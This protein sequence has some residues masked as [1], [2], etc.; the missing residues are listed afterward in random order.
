[1]KTKLNIK[2]NKNVL[3]FL[4]FLA[5][6]INSY[7]QNCA[8]NLGEVTLQNIVVTSNTLEYDIYV[9]NIGTT[10]LK[11][12][13]FNGNAVY[14]A[15]LLGAGTGTFTVIQ[16][17]NVC[18]FPTL[19]NIVL[20]HT[21]ASQQLRYTQTIQ[22]FA[23]GNQ[24]D[25]PFNVSMKFAR[26]RLT[27]SVPFA[28]TSFTLRLPNGADPV[29]I[30]RNNLTVTCN[31]N[32]NTTNLVGNSAPPTLNVGGPYNLNVPVVNCPTS[33]TW[34]GTTWSNGAP[35]NTLH[36]IFNGNYSSTASID[37]CQVTIGNNSNVTINPNHTL[38]VNYEI[39]VQTGS[40]LTIENDAAIKQVNN[41]TNTGNTIIKR[42]SAPIIRLDYTAW[43]SPVSG[44]QLLSFSPNTL[45]NRFYTYDSNGTTTATAFL[46]IAPTNNFS[47]GV[48]YLIRAANDW[49]PT[50]YS[51]FNGTY[52]GILNNGTYNVPIG[53][54]YNMI[55]NPYA[56]PIN[57]QT[58]LT[59]NATIGT[60]Y[61]WTHTI[62]A[63]GS[64]YPTNN[65]ASFTTLGGAAA[66]AGGT[67]PNG[68]IQTGQGFFVNSSAATNAV[69]QNSLRENATTSTQFYRNLNTEKHRFWV[70]LNGETVNHNQILIGYMDTATNSVDADIDGKLIDDSSSVIY[71]YL[72]NE[73]YVI[74][75]KTLPFVD[76]DIV[77]LG[78]KIN[79]LG[80]YT[81]NLETKDGIFT[82]QNI[83]LK[84][85]Y[86]NTIQ[87]LDASGYTFNSASGVFND[88]FEIV[89][90][91]NVLGNET[92]NSSTMIVFVN[93]NNEIEI[94][95]PK[96]TIKAV[97][98]Y[99]VVG[100]RIY[101]NENIN[102]G[103]LIINKQFDTKV[104]FIKT[105]LENGKT[106][107]N[108]LLINK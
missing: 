62:P 47:N 43:S 53:N 42:N 106:I 60:L 93:A 46:P 64:V 27:N 13:G 100:K 59:Q 101:N 84:D 72:D 36:A 3:T 45:T 2:R 24:V 30:T 40:T 25:M 5:F 14:T 67:I 8:G 15:G 48:G 63:V 26:V 39:D 38:T 35:N 11:L 68:Y 92:F 83:Y 104:V 94:S 20:T 31:G 96:E 90:Q 77:P 1:M 69:F 103:N 17:P 61:F 74:Q 32:V 105:F 66:A 82:S 70:N 50:I 12:G 56:S 6:S 86:T 99:D 54:G 75:G 55:G 41:A 97:E 65:Y 80:I 76:T 102:S 98:L 23:S 7:S 57:A 107:N 58:F 16:Q 29:S 91:N 19:S 81:I 73:K 88:R 79:D 28:L 9:R 18:D 44:Q 10:T 49:S 4:L 87:L 22:N 71:N 78:I 85:K 52:S 21:A 37:A 108:K 33:T 89:Y 34:N 95:S 51:P